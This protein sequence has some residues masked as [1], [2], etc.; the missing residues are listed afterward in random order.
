MIEIVATSYQ[1]L[2]L[3]CTKFDF[4]WGSASARLLALPLIP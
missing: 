2:R 3:I 1:I 4:G